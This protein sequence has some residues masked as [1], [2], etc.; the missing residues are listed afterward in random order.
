MNNK[1]QTQRNNKLDSQRNNKLD[2]QRN[3]K[4]DKILD[5]KIQTLCNI[6]LAR[7]LGYHQLLQRLPQSD[8]VYLASLQKFSDLYSAL[9]V[10]CQNKDR[11]VFLLG[12]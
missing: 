10:Y 2:S 3:N 11:S 6:I 8:Q 4:L 12:K 1:L 9:S 7:G 5:L